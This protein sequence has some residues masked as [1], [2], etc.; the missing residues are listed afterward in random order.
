ME[1]PA[2][3]FKLEEF[4]GESKSEVS[5]MSP[6]VDKSATTTDSSAFITGTLNSELKSNSKLSIAKIVSDKIN[7]NGNVFQ[8]LNYNFV[9][10]ETPSHGVV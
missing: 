2:G 3:E 6:S 10:L 8:I 1:S 9:K 7:C 5:K 4:N